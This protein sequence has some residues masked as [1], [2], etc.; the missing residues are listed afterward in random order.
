MNTV[1][2]SAIQIQCGNVKFYPQTNMKRC[3]NLHEIY[4]KL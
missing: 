4:V 1:H 3:D 2:K